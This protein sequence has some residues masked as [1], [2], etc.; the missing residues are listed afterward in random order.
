MANAGLQDLAVAPHESEGAAAVATSQGLYS[1]CGT[2]YEVGTGDTVVQG[3]CRRGW[4][5]PCHRV[6]PEPAL[7]RAIVPGPK[8]VIALGG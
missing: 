4:D 3:G 5:A 7:R 8:V 2:A 6:A 1:L